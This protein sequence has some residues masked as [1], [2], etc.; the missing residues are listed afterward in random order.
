MTFCQIECA[1]IPVLFVLSE[2]PDENAR[3]IEIHEIVRFSPANS[4]SPDAATVDSH[5]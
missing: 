3:R 1:Y 4:A 5:S 2:Q